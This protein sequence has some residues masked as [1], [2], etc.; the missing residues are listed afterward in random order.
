MDAS[1][2]NFRDQRRDRILQVAREVFFEVGYAGASMSTISSRLGGSKATLYAYFAS[3]EDLFAAIV[4]DSCQEMAAV[5]EAHIGTDD[6][7]QSLATVARQMVSMI[8]SDWGTNIMQLVIE[9]GRRNPGLAKTFEAAIESNGRKAMRA[10]LTTAHDRGQIEIP[11]VDEAAVILKSLVFG[12]LQ[13]KRLLN[14]APPP[15]EAQLH[16][17][18]DVAIDV[19]L[20][21][22]ACKAEEAK[23]G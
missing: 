12:D 18:I 22:F 7:R 10:L 23:P 11:D 9:E 6:L 5:F 4:R 2:P 21:Y 14:L 16:H 13:F 19:F 17:H 3:K 8:V 20:T 15:S 1:A